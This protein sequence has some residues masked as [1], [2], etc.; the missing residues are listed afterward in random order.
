MKAYGALELTQSSP[1]QSFTEPLTLAEAKAFLRIPDY[2][3]AD[4]DQDALLLGLI[5]AAREMAEVA[6]NRDLVVKQYDLCLDLL[7]GHDAIAGA[8][9][10]LRYNS[11]YNFGVGYDIPLRHP[12]RT[13][14]LFQHH[15][16]DGSTTALAEGAD[17]L[18]DLNRSLVCPPWGKVWPFFTPWPTSSVLIRF[19][20]G[21]SPDHPFW[22]DAGQR[23]KLGMK[24]LIAQWHEGRIPV[25]QGSHQELP[26]AVTALLGTGARPRVF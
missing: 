26:Y 12:L 18:V 20:S 3:P 11:I 10:P 7:L 14:D 4:T 19:T 2:S 25:V 21:Y 13:V 9:Y 5:A 23:I 22:L 1:P 24:M 17:Y 6:Q 16:R 8:A 15:D